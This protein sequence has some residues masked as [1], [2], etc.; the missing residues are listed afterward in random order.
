LKQLLTINEPAPKAC[1]E[2]TVQSCHEIRGKFHK[3]NT[4]HI[5]INVPPK[6]CDN[7]IQELALEDSNKNL[8]S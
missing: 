5:N 8:V 7:Q 1:V 6:N 3:A 2:A 4:G